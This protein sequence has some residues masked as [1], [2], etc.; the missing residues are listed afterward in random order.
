[1]KVDGQVILATFLLSQFV[2]LGM[3]PIAA[4]VE[5]VG[6]PSGAIGDFVPCE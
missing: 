5:K 3:A 4:I 1:V 2:S 6:E